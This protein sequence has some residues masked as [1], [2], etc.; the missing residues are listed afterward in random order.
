[1]T[2]YILQDWALTVNKSTR[3]N[4]FVKDA[5]ELPNMKVVWLRGQSH[6]IRYVVA[7]IP[8][9]FLLLFMLQKNSLAWFAEHLC[10]S[11]PGDELFYVI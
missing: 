5:A 1:M 7:L 4:H 10:L 6:I 11:L 2:L 9:S 3:D 8:C